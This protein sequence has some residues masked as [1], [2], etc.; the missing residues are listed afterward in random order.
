MDVITMMNNAM[1]GV[2]NAKIEGLG[3]TGDGVFYHDGK[4]YFLPNTL[5]GETVSFR[6]TGDTPELIDI[7]EASNSRVQ[8]S[9]TI[10]NDCGGCAVQHMTLPAL[11]SWKTDRITRLLSSVFSDVPEPAHYQTPPRTRRRMDLAVQ[12]IPGGVHIGLHARNGDPVD[13]IACDVLAPELFELLTPLRD[14]LAGLGA[15]TGRADLQINLLDTGPDLTLSTPTALSSADRAKL[16]AFAREHNIR[17]IAWTPIG[18]REIETVAQSRAPTIRFGSADVTP[19][20]A[21]FLQASREAERVIQDAVL[22]GLPALNKKDIIVE[23]YAGCGTLTL[24]MSDNGRVIAYEGDVSAAAS[25]RTASGGRR[26]DAHTRDLV[27]QPLLPPDL[28]TARVVVLDPPYTGAGPQIE[29][30]ARS[31]VKD[32][33]YVS[34]NPAALKKDLQTLHKAGFELISSTVV[35]QFLW[36]TEVETVVVLSRDPKRI[37]RESSR[38]SRSA[39]SHSDS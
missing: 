29:P 39:P 26:I 24:P 16:A 18:K 28:K 23:L 14:V 30:L 32:L 37:K 36:S 17:R 38:R 2:L 31:T 12:R 25:L 19:P 35:D 22:A 20:P 8:P 13:M 34:C 21:A 4:T 11:L 27:R 9:C 10:I 15:L 1:S 33:V 7:L 5:P 6:F 3:T